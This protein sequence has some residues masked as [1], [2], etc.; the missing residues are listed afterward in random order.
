MVMTT[1]Q[2]T[3]LTLLLAKSVVTLTF[4]AE[5]LVDSEKT[6]DKV[7]ELLI[8]GELVTGDV[9]RFL[10]ALKQYPRIHS[11]SLDS[12]GGSVVEAIRM[13]EAIR[14]AYLETSV[15]PEKSCVSACFFLFVAGTGRLASHSAAMSK[16]FQKEL[17]ELDR[18]VGVR[19]KMY[20][21]VGLHRPYFK[22]PTE[23]NTKQSELMR[24]VRAYMDNLLI[25][26]RLID[27]MMSRPSNEIYWLSER[28]L[29]EL[30]TYGPDQEENFVQQ[31]GYVRNATSKAIDLKSERRGANAVDMFQNQLKAQKC[32]Y[33]IIMSMRER[34]KVQIE[35]GWRPTESPI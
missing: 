24:R 4:A 25:P 35:K 10:A 28:D 18:K 8:R 2:L 32:I 29:E 21:F 27:L 12:S 16:A 3:L 20:G 13:G 23:I 11:V 6:Q 22:A 26:R 7:S 34:A 1:K 5:F 19:T 33:P 30:G 31:C 9:D 17:R 15:Q 14:F